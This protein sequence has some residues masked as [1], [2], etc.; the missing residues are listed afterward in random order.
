M[1]NTLLMRA[2]R[3]FWIAILAALAVTGWTLRTH[4]SVRTTRD[5]AVVA[6]TPAFATPRPSPTVAASPPGHAAA[7]SPAPEPAVPVDLP[8]PAPG[9][10]RALTSDYRKALTAHGHKVLGLTIVDTRATG[11][12]RR[13][14]IIY[15]TA[16]DGSMKALRP[17]VA[18]IVSPGA[19]PRLA[20]DQIVVRPA[21][22]NGAVVVTVTVTVMELDRWLKAQTT[23][24][25]FYESWSV[26]QSAR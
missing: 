6:D 4:W 13:A 22:P 20:L 16:T 21:R 18:R 8:T 1:A 9:L 5:G 2:H 11:G 24:E 7:P 12:A 17:E 10:D 25:E 3:L 14:E 26:R 19:N 15:Q 23:D